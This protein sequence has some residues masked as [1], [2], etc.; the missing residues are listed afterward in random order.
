MDLPD[1]RPRSFH[2]SASRISAGN[3][4][5][6]WSLQSDAVVPVAYINLQPPNKNVDE[7][8]GNFYPFP[9]VCSFGV[10]KNGLM[11]NAESLQTTRSVE[12]RSMSIGFRYST[13]RFEQLN[14]REVFLSSIVTFQ[15]SSQ[16]HTR[17]FCFCP[18]RLAL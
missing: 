17:V 10:K 15:M 5:S 8:G 13:S 11:I 16:N 18:G 12:I 7:T 14:I 4:Y 1:F 2:G 9:N 6:I 3:S